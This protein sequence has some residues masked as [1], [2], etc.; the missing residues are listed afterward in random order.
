MT[1]GSRRRSTGEAQADDPSSA[2]FRHARLPGDPPQR[3]GGLLGNIAH[4]DEENGGYKATHDR[5]VVLFPGSVLH[6]RE[7]PR[8]RRRGPKPAEVKKAPKLRTP[9]WIMAAEM[10]RPARLYARTCARLDPAWVLDLG[11]HLLR[12]TSHSEPFWNPEAAA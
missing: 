2:A 8:R 3:A 1:S 9:R 5:K 4:L 10:W 6:R 7:E 11:S 12:V